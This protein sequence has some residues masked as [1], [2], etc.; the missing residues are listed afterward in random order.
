MRK[1]QIIPHYLPHAEGSVLIK[2][3]KTQVICT[4]S[5]SSGVPKFRE[6]SGE[7]WLTAEYGMLPRSTSTRMERDGIR[8]K[9]NGRTVEISR[10][11]GRALRAAI[12]L[13]AL[14]KN[15]IQ[16]DCDVIQADGG[17][18]CASITGAMVALYLALLWMQKKK[19]LPTTTTKK[20][21]LKNFIAAIS[22]GIVNGK[23][24]ADLCYTQDRQASVDMNFVMTDDGKYIEIQGTAEHQPFNEKQ[25]TQLKKI[26]TREIK[27]IIAY[28]KRIVK[29]K[30]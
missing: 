25:L 15:T 19:M 26:A 28:Q 1:L 22:V 30:K 10:L 7:G 24:L 21:P 9:Q 16:I 17:T 27:K 14:G 23:P 29:R 20:L 4:A 2:C 6:K 11:I 18:R 8:G 12:D 13:S 5:V 3:G